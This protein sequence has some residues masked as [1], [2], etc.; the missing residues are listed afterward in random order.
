M[1][2]R[3]LPRSAFGKTPG[4]LAGAQ[5][6]LEGHKSVLGTRP[7]VSLPPYVHIPGRDLQD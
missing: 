5:V 2:V 4:T 1:K 3:R 7:V 6:L